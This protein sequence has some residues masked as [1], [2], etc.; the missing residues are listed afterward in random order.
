MF[1]RGCVLMCLEH[2]SDKKSAF[3]RAA[4]C[5]IACMAVAHGKYRYKYN[6][7]A[8][9]FVVRQKMT[10]S[11]T[12]TARM[13]QLWKISCVTNLAADGTQARD[14]HKLAGGLGLQRMA[15][16]LGGQEHTGS[17]AAAL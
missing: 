12:G 6:G 16:M 1:L 8:H 9:N 14:H 7:G 11:I 3:R 2:A 10:C 13:H 17:C 15:P 5:K 4:E